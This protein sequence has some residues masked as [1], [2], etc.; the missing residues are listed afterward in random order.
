MSKFSQEQDVNE[1]NEA[2]LKRERAEHNKKVLSAYRIQPKNNVAPISK[3]E[4]GLQPKEKVYTLDCG[5]NVIAVDFRSI[6][7]IRK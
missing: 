1:S 4:E 2:R 5:D 3:E 6:S 7:R